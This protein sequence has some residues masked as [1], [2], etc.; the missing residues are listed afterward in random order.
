M[1][2]CNCAVIDKASSTPDINT[3]FGGKTVMEGSFIVFSSDD[4][5]GLICSCS[6]IRRLSDCINGSW[7]YP[8]GKKISTTS[9]ANQYFVYESSYKTDISLFHNGSPPERGKFTCTWSGS[10]FYVYII[11]L[12]NKTGP[13]SMTVHEGDDTELSVSVDIAH[14]NNYTEDIDS[15]IMYQWQ[16]NGVNVKN[17]II[18]N[19]K[20]H[21]TQQSAN[22]SIFNV[23]KS[24]EGSYRCVFPNIYLSDGPLVSNEVSLNVGK[25]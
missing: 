6:G 10:T 13:F 17:T 7:S 24:D 22:L 1:Y 8:N 18:G 3:Q 23:Q 16:K 25:S 15:Q 11:D 2:L 14:N 12:L 20:Y 21:G 5:E 4:K 19:T 9:D